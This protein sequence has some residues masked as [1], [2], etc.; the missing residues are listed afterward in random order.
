MSTT[1][2]TE[3]GSSGQTLNC[4]MAGYQQL[5]SEIVAAALGVVT[6][7]ISIGEAIL[8]TDLALS[9][10]LMYKFLRSAPGWIGYVLA[11]VYYMAED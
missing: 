4:N 10:D 6:M 5:V 9:L 2:T 11:A 1:T 7:A 3:A 8:P